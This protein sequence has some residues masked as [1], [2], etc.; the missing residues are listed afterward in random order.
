MGY[1]Y[2]RLGDDDF[3]MLC[4][5]LVLREFGGV[6][7]MPTGMA[8]GGRDITAADGAVV[9]QVKFSASSRA[10]ASPVTWLERAIKG[11]LQKVTALAARGAKRYV[12]VTNLAGTSHPGTGGIDRIQEFLDT[13]S[14][15]PATCWWAGD[16]D[17]RL[18]DAFDLKLRH[19]V[20][21]DGQDMLRAIAEHGGTGDADRLWRALRAYLRGEAAADQ[22]VRFRQA[23]DLAAPLLELFVDVPAAPT[24]ASAQPGSPG[25]LDDPRTRR[26]RMATRTVRRQ[27]GIDQ[28]EGRVLASR[29]WEAGAAAALLDSRVGAHFP[30]VVVEGAPGQ[31]KSTLAQYL[32]QVHRIRLLHAPETA[33]L[34]PAHR[35]AP[36]MLPIKLELR[37]LAVWLT[38]RTPFDP[39]GTEHRQPR[40]LEAALAAQVARGSGGH[41]F[42][43]AD[44]AAVA[45]QTPLLVILDALDEV[46]DLPS[47]AAA[48]AEVTAAAARLTGTGARIVVTSRPTALP[49]A[50]ALDP[51]VFWHVSLKSMEPRLALDYAA[52]WA[53]VW[54][55][56]EERAAEVRQVLASRLTDDHCAELARNAMQLSIL[57]TLIRQRGAQL[58]ERRTELY[59]KYVDLYFDREGEKHP[60]VHSHRELFIDMHRDLAFR[61]HA[62]A[63]HRGATGRITSKALREVIDEHLR[64]R[65][66]DP[67]LADDMLIG[68]AERVYFLTARTEGLYEF[69]NQPMREYFAAQHLYKTT[70]YRSAT[71]GQSGG[72]LRSRF[73]G[74]AANPFWGNVTRFMAG[75]FQSS[76]L[77]GLADH[78]ADLIAEQSGPTE[79]YVRRLATWMLS[80]WVFAHNLRAARRLIEA[81]FDADG[82]AWVCAAPRPNT[83]SAGTV[84]VAAIP[85][86]PP[87]CAPLL[88]EV[89]WS[90]ITDSTG[91]AATERALRLAGVL[92]RQHGRHDRA[93]RWRTELAGRSGPAADAWFAIGAAL[94]VFRGLPG[95]Q[96][97]QLLGAELSAAALLA[98]VRGGADPDRLAPDTPD[99]AR[100]AYTAVLNSARPYARLPL[101]PTPVQYLTEMT[102]VERWIGLASSDRHSR[103]RDALNHAASRGSVTGIEDAHPVSAIRAALSGVF[104]AGGGAGSW[105]PFIAA[106]HQ[107][108]GPNLTAAEL[109]VVLAGPAGSWLPVTGQRLGQGPASEQATA[110]AHNAADAEWWFVQHRLA[111]STE[112]VDSVQVTVN[113]YLWAL[114]LIVWADAAVVAQC[115]PALAQ[116]VTTLPEAFADALSA[117]TERAKDYTA[118]RDEAPTDLPLTATQLAGSGLPPE[119]VSALLPRI[120]DQLQVWAVTELIGADLPGPAAASACL[121]TLIDHRAELPTADLID[122]VVVC[123]RAGGIPSGQAAALMSGTRH[124]SG[125]QLD[126]LAAQ[127][128]SHAA[129]L[130]GCFLTLLYDDGRPQNGRGETVLALAEQ[131]HWFDDGL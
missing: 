5:S 3:Q 74:I 46:A 15:I 51:S 22:Q 54:R 38:G 62:E 67:A 78:M 79:A 82:R 129:E 102:Q 100:A 99:S 13:H 41:L 115:L 36:L 125:Q 63:E 88:T 85:T 16:L 103:A 116:T 7:C 131:Q 95:P 72:D 76:E 45:E 37:D 117:A 109:T 77:A 104:A 94:G 28:Q 18:D 25:Y 126:E 89:L 96:L 21:L 31:G 81:V 1:A 92:S 87:T 106:L 32:A 124:V 23:D 68:T 108:F 14:P 64:Q 17:R 47:R 101:R 55:L 113:R 66:L 91:P 111:H 107:Q 58:P 48:V 43:V 29:R 56:S 80:D 42:E 24:S 20:L 30:L 86:L 121:N 49:G 61:L 40:T 9:F 2:D 12:L 35:D 65:G 97:N 114:A 26:W 53:R 123:Y 71:E 59:D 130:P 19:P 110:I 84:G 105:D 90:Y 122:A 4:Q 11:E 8:D 6:Q 119:A 52:R 73:A 70:V 83:A 10:Q 120:P 118:A 128:R 44:L 57:L 98:T 75:C 50:P 69:D 33:Q 27:R 34:P 93:Q 60:I 39:G 112:T 127:V